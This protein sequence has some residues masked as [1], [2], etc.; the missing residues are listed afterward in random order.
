MPR[1]RASGS[2]CRRPRRRGRGHR[3][4]GDDCRPRLHA[5]RR[6]RA[7][8]GRAWPQP[9]PAAALQ[10]RRP[11]SGRQ[12]HGRGRALRLPA[13]HGRG[14]VGGLGGRAGRGRRP[15]T[16]MPTFFRPQTRARARGQWVGSIAE[17]ES[18]TF[19]GV[20]TSE[21]PLARTYRQLDLDE[22]RPL[23]R[24]IEARTPVG[25][26]AARL[27]RHPSTVY[28]ELG[29]NR[30]RDGDRGFCGYFPLNAQDLA[31]R[32][33]QRRRKLAMNEGLRAHVTERL[34]AGWSP[35]QI[36]GRLRHEADGGPTV[37]HETIY[38]HVYGPE[39]REDGL[40]RHLPKA[41]RRR[42]SRY[43]RRPRSASI[44]R[45]RWIEN[46]PAEVGD[47]QVFGHWEADLLIFR[48][49]H[50]KANV[51]SLVERKSR[52][53]FLLPNEDKRSTAV[54]AGIAGALRGLPEDARRTVTFDRG[55]EFAGYAA[56]DRD[57]AV[58][59]YFCDPHSPWQKGGVE[60]LNGRARRFLP[61]ESPAEALA[62]P[63]LPRLADRLNDTPRRCLGY[64]TP[65]EV[66]EQ[67]LAAPT[68]PP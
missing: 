13:N 52:F 15:V 22:R 9:A 12:G 38:R 30:F 27:G 10:P 66:F 40:Y 21:T 4:R 68:G 31:R 8:A 6:L 18:P 24:L 35:Q 57:L 3:R 33:R 54:I 60:N 50:G 39:G 49:E 16:G 36:A 14:G 41:R 20:C 19:A 11:A 37:C 43:G 28:R 29:R 32:R 26:I 23:F 58:E 17:C 48:K 64:R 42:G 2:S 59:A 45:E 65:R 61:R 62:R 1:S 47:R 67:H 5:R 25:E 7:A 46:R 63:P 55:S 51:T 56:L 53:T 34:E 44:P